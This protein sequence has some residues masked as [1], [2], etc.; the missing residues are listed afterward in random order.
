MD[1]KQLPTPIE[2]EDLENLRVAKRKLESPSLTVELAALVGQPLEAGMKLLPKRFS[3]RVHAITQAALLRAIDIAIGSLAKSPKVGKHEAMHRWLSAGSGAIG[4]A[5]GLWSLPVEIPISTTLVLRAIADIARDEGH[6]LS[7]LDVR[8]ACLEV[9][10]LGGASA[11][12][13]AAES[14]YWIIR[15][16]LSKA[17]ADAATHLTQRGLVSEGAPPLVRLAATLASRFSVNLS[18]QAAA[19]A[20]P[21][22]SAVSG[23]AINLLFMQHFQEMARGHFIVKRLEAKYGSDAIQRIYADL[24]I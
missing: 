23:A 1:D 2:A 14:S 13:N 6:D 21:V 17:F 20:I 18:A 16:S 4:G 11:Q 8:L 10:A 5:V 7:R 24:D 15:G 22:V 19:K 9:F 12:D 3:G